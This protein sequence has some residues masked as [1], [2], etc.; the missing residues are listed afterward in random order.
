MRH[1]QPSSFSDLL[2]LLPGGVSKDPVMGNFDGGEY[3]DES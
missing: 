1:L 3:A 2:E